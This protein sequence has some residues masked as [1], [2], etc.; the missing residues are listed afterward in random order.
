[1]LLYQYLSINKQS[2]IRLDSRPCPAWAKRSNM[3]LFRPFY[4]VPG[5]SVS[6]QLLLPIST[7]SCL[8]TAIITVLFR[9]LL[10]PLLLL[11]FSR[12]INNHLGNNDQLAAHQ[13]MQS[14]LLSQA[15]YQ[16]DIVNAVQDDFISS[17]VAN[18]NQ[19]WVSC[20][21]TIR[22]STS[23]SRQPDTSNLQVIC[24]LPGHIAVPATVL[25]ILQTHCCQEL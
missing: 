21:S 23:L 11:S 3:S 5:V 15:N 1:M 24:R 22:T 9:A 14:K 18:A 7:G 8:L 6:S 20:Q 17:L 4:T 16:P 25:S 12:Q 10:L 13:L 19:T 2:K